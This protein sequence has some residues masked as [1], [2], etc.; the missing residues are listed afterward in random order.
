LPQALI[1]PLQDHLRLVRR[2]HDEDLSHGYG[3]V[4]LPFA[5]ERKY[6]HAN[7]E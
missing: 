3:A 4:Y 1:V 7:R 2:T 6:Q 5:L